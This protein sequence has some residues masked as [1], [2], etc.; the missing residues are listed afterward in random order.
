MRGQIAALLGLALTVQSIPAVAQQVDRIG[1]VGLPRRSAGWN[2]GSE[3]ERELP[4]LH[5][6]RALG[7]RGAGTAKTPRHGKLLAGGAG[8]APPSSSH[9]PR[10]A[11]NH[12]AELRQFPPQARLPPHPHHHAVHPSHHRCTG[13]RMVIGDQ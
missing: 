5:R 9:S 4:G 10:R 2:C 11:L 1:W 8:P 12:V 7:A 13:Q 3:A 6:Q